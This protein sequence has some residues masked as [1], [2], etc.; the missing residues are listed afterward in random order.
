MSNTFWAVFYGSALGMITVNLVTAL[1][2][3]WR[4]KQHH[5]QLEQL[6][7]FLEDFEFEEDEK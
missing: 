3:E 7:Q 4:H 5:K 2:E 6:G 1:I